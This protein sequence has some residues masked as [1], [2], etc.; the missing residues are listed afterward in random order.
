[1]NYSESWFQGSNAINKYKVVEDM[2][3]SRLQLGALDDGKRLR[4][5]MTWMNPGREVLVLDAM[6]SSRLWMVWMDQGC[7]LRVMVDMNSLGSWALSPKWY[8]QLKV[9]DDVSYFG[10]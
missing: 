1:M 4:L 10:S 6:N 7:E 3:K 8:E 2:N 5:E 9:M